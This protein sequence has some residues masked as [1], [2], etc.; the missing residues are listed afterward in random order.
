MKLNR[1]CLV[2]PGSRGK[3]SHRVVSIPA[4]TKGENSR[5]KDSPVQAMW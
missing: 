4:M 2:T 3:E 5:S 1:G